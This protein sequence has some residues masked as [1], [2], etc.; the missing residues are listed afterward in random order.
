MVSANSRRGSSPTAAAGPRPP[1]LR[2]PAG[3][4]AAAARPPPPLEPVHGPA[5][6][7]VSLIPLPP[8]AALPQIATGR[9]SVSPR[10][11]GSLSPVRQLVPLMRQGP[12]MFWRGVFG[13]LPV[14]ATQALVG[15]G[16]IVAFTRLL[17]PE[18]YG[19]YALALAAA[20]VVHA[21]FLVWIEAAMERFT[22]RELE[23]GEAPP[24]RH[25]A[26]RLRAAGVVPWSPRPSRCWSCR[27]THELR[28][29]VAA[30][31]RL[32]AHRRRGPA[33][34]G[35]PARRGPRGR[36]RRL[37]HHRPRSAASAWAPSS[38]S[39]GWGGASVLA[40]PGHRHRFRPCAAARAR[41]GAAAAAAASSRT[42]LRCYAAYG[43]PVALSHPAEPG[44][45]QRRPLPDRGLPRRGAASA[46]TT[47]ATAWRTARSTS[48]SP[49]SR[50]PAAR[51]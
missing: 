24:L 13:Y 27:W 34:A 22:L 49:G 41:A 40:R 9:P 25:P 51:R 32:A 20:A 30:G 46:T 16:S 39:P 15:F 37:R 10:V 47:P 12:S 21:L 50:S 45:V 28:V 3:R 43:L 42:G 2:P 26:R 5:S 7:L 36:L 14:Q 17:T 6:P 23:R 1:A 33:D 29:A 18:Q 38:P 44:A 31:L 35:A 48:C 4:P 8:G 19:Q 11:R